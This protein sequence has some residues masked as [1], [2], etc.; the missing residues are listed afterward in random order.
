MT[1][2]T[3]GAPRPQS[4]LA[5]ATLFFAALLLGGASLVT[6]VTY[7]ANRGTDDTS[8]AVW[9]A[10]GLAAGLITLLAPSEAARAVASR[11]WGRATSATLAALLCGSF[12]IAGALGSASSG[13]N[14]AVATAESSTNERTRQ[15][16]T[17]TRITADLTALTPARPAAELRA[18]IKPLD[19]RI[20]TA[21]CGNWVR[22]LDV[23]AACANRNTLQV[24]LARADRRVDLD[25]QLATAMSALSTAGAPPVEANADA[26]ALAGY[27]KI[28][29]YS[30]DAATLNDLLTILAVLVVE[31]G[32]ALALGLARGTQMSQTVTPAT[33]ASVPRSTVPAMAAPIAANDLEGVPAAPGLA[34]TLGPAARG[35]AT[36][37]TVPAYNHTDDESVVSLRIIEAARA[38][39]GT[40]QTSVRRLASQVAAP[41]TTVHRALMLLAA[42]GALEL[43]TSPAG[44]LVKLAA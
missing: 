25:Q 5:S 41:K 30:V 7:A 43:A 38:S 17:Y 22:N 8:T 40:L 33:A 28:L 27:L 32:G 4:K 44:T 11:H 9:S 42:A 2:H 37:A 13:R 20:G 29:G 1:I 15:L 21:D 16:A 6:A 12:A 31:V 10:V 3:T 34:G 36:T 35:L 39:G 26:K 24:E 23:R 14:H 18:M 19:A